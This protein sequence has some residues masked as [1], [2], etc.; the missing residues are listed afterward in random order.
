M[1]LHIPVAIIYETAFL[2]EGELPNDQVAFSNRLHLWH[3]ILLKTIELGLTDN[4]FG[5]AAVD[6]LDLWLT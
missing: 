4:D 3:P 5:A 1:L 6:V 2:R